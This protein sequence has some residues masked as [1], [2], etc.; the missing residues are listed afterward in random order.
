MELR[1]WKALLLQWVQKCNFLTN[2]ICLEDSEIEEFF[3]QYTQY[4]QVGQSSGRSAS[5]PKSPS[6]FSPGELQ[7]FLKDVYP[8]FKPLLER[9]GRI[10][11]NDYAYVYT[12]LMHYACVQCPSEYFHNI[13]RTLPD[14]TQQYIAAFFTQ[15]MIN[16]DMNRSH[17]RETI[18]GI[19]EIVESADSSPTQP[20]LRGLT[21]LTVGAT[22]DNNGDPKASELDGKDSASIDNDSTVGTNFATPNPVQRE[23]S[24]LLDVSLNYAPSTP[25]TVL[26]EQRTRE[27]LGLR[28]QLETERYEK[29]VLEDQIL[30]NE[31][32]INSLSKENTVK[33]Q[34]L[35]KLE[36]SLEYDS[37]E[38]TYIH[39]IVPDEIENLKRQLLKEINKKEAFL[40]QSRDEVQVLRDNY[41]ILAERHKS[42]EEQLYDCL[43]KVENLELRLAAATQSLTT[44]DAEISILLRDKL[45][46]ERC[47]QE[48]RTEL[49]NGR[50]VLNASSDLLDTSQSTASMNT[51]PETLASSVID[52]QLREK[53]LENDDLRDQLDAIAREKKSILHELLMIVQPYQP[54]ISLSP[55][56]SQIL[57]LVERSFEDMAD[58]YKREQKLVKE[59]QAEI[60]E[61]RSQNKL[62]EEG[63]ANKVEE[64]LKPS[65]FAPPV[66]VVQCDIA[67]QTIKEESRLTPSGEVAQCDI[68]VQTIKEESQLTPPV[69]VEQCDIAVQTIPEPSKEQLHI[70]D[71]KITKIGSEL[72]KICGINR[73]LLQNR[74]ITEN[75]DPSV[76]TQELQDLEMRILSKAEIIADQ[77]K[78]IFINQKHINDYQQQLNETNGQL[79]AA[80]L[81]LKGIQQQL[82]EYQ[83][84]LKDTKEALNHVQEEK[85]AAEQKVGQK[86][87]GHASDY[88]QQIDSYQQQLIEYQQKLNE[89]QKQLNNSQ[90]ELKETEKQLNGSKEQL[91]ATNQQL[92][93]T[94]KQLSSYQHQLTDYQKRLAG[95]Q[96]LLDDHESIQHPIDSEQVVN[97]AQ[98][99]LS[100][101]QKQL[102]SFIQTICARFNL[103]A[104]SENGLEE[105][106]KTLIDWVEQMENQLK[107]KESE[108]LQQSEDLADVSTLTDCILDSMNPYLRPAIEDVNTE[109]LPLK[110]KF[111]HNQLKQLV[112]NYERANEKC[113]ALER[114]V[115]QSVEVRRQEQ[116]TMERQHN[117]VILRLTGKL[118]QLEMQCDKVS[119]E[120][121]LKKL[122]CENI[123]EELRIQKDLNLAHRND[124]SKT[125]GD[126][127]DSVEHKFQIDRNIN[128][129]T[130]EATVQNGN[131]I[132]TESV[133]LAAIKEG[134]TAA[135]QMQVKLE[136]ELR[137]KTSII[138]MGESTIQRLQKEI[139]AKTKQF[140]EQKDELERK[141]AEQTKLFQTSESTI[142]TLQKELMEKSQQFE[143][144]K[145]ELEQELREKT[146]LIEMGES[147]IEALQKEIMVKSQQFEKSR[148]ELELELAEKSK[149]VQMGESTIETLQKEI[150]KKSQQFEKSRNE[151]DLE[152][153][154]KS[155]IVQIG[156][157]TIETLQK[158]IKEKTELFEKSRSELERVLAEKT[159]VL[160]LNEST[161]QALQKE[162]VAKSE[163]LEKINSELQRELAEKTRLLHMGEATIKTLQKEIMAKSVQLE[164]T[165]G[166][167]EESEQKLKSAQQ[168]L[169]LA[170]QK[171][172]EKDLVATEVH[173]LEDLLKSEQHKNLSL[174]QEKIQQIEQKRIIEKQLA[175]VQC[176]ICKR[177]DELEKTK[178][179][180]EA[181]TKRL[182][183]ISI[184][185]GEQQAILSKTQREMAQS[186]ARQTEQAEL[187]I[188]LQNE[189]ESLQMELRKT[190]E[191]AS[192]SEEK[193]ATLEQL[194]IEAESE[195]DAHRDQLLR[196]ERESKKAHCIIRDLEHQAKATEN[197]KVKLVHEIG[198][199]N[200][201]IV[202]QKKQLSELKDQLQQ[203]KDAMRDLII[204]NENNAAASAEQLDQDRSSL[205][206]LK[207]ELSTARQE[208]EA[209]KQQH[210]SLTSELKDKLTELEAERSKSKECELIFKR[211][212]S[213]LS[214]ELEKCNAELAETR[215][216]HDELIKATEMQTMERFN[217]LQETQLQLKQQRDTLIQRDLDCQIL[218]AKYRET[219]EEMSRCEQRLKDHRLEMEGKLEKM[220]S[221]MRTLYTA[222]VSRIKE[223]QERE[224]ANHKAEL[225]KLNAQVAKYEEHTRKLSDQIMRLNEKLLEEQKK[226]AIVSTQLRH[227]QEAEQPA[228]SSLPAVEDWQPFKRPSAPSANLGSNLAMEDEEGE[229]FNNTYLTDLKLG[230]VPNMTAEE[231]QY[232]NS[233]QPPHLKSAYA[234]QYDLG[235][236]EDDIKDGPH[237]LDDSMSALLSTTDG[238]GVGM[239]K[240]SMGTHYKRPGP[241]TPS[242]NGGRLSFG[243]SEPPREI[244]RET[245][246]NNGT[247]K[248]PARFKIFASRF[249]IGNGGGGGGGQCLPRDE[250]RR[251]RK[252][253][254]LKG[255]M[256][257]R[258]LQTAF[259]TSTPRSSRS[260]YDQRQQLIVHGDG[261]PDGQQPLK[262]EQEVTP[263]LNDALPLASSNDQ[264]GRPSICRRR[265]ITT[266][267]SSSLTSATQS[268]SSGRR[269]KSI[270]R[271][272]IHLYGNRGRSRARLSSTAQMSHK[273][274]QQ[275]SKIK[276]QR[277]GCFDRGRQLLDTDDDPTAEPEEV[278]DEEE[279][280]KE[281]LKLANGTY[282]LPKPN[283]NNNYCVLNRNNGPLMAMG[284]T[285]LLDKKS[286]NCLDIKAESELEHSSDSEAATFSVDRAAVNNSHSHWDDEE[287]PALLKALVAKYECDRDSNLAALQQFEEDHVCAWLSDGA[288]TSIAAVNNLSYDI[289]FEELCRQTASTAPFE[290]Q[291]LQY[292]YELVETVPQRQAHSAS[293]ATENTSN[294]S[295]N[296]NC[297][298]LQSWT[299]YSLSHIR[300]HRLPHINVTT[301]NRLSESRH[302]PHRRRGNILLNLWQRRRHRIGLIKS[303]SL[304]IVLFLFLMPFCSYLTATAAV[305]LMLLLL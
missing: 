211:K 209:V 135:N 285:V 147:T 21:F 10:M 302:L 140:G 77:E 31:Q 246:D 88:Q 238:N 168:K 96:K 106:E 284:A 101:K 261:P 34:Q 278:E 128:I 89:T 254:L 20:Q 213:V 253:S 296:T 268:V 56:Y 120:L 293:N 220:K 6:P 98:Q 301:M 289:H 197:E 192:R 48:A 150:M 44:K 74:F 90:Q 57:G 4:V 198:G 219:K 122:E 104:A 252:E 126:S 270:S 82:D 225:E 47:L 32:L 2:V 229:V 199:L 279:D 157:A 69:D 272:S 233:L 227:L 288:S 40:A 107:Q 86:L 221:K 75:Q 24:S 230:T 175:D 214:K 207:S 67:V 256:H 201:E 145:S 146:K 99:E 283:E 159:E 188:A 235:A 33:K 216:A 23:L 25:K 9:N 231:L 237:S 304:G 102:Q 156:E 267:S 121:T 85:I 30:E 11:T 15:A 87:V 19:T 163:N 228:M 208:L 42:C 60:N 177:E 35:A 137:E 97:E 26:L 52:K 202:Q 257:R 5:S 72:I 63:T 271:K 12:L 124:V 117:D 114:K 65:Q 166:E 299:T 149:I 148:N 174:E 194:R 3:K 7:T 290:L 273:R 164:K 84:K 79:Q 195:R 200:S 132:E 41:N 181:S 276:D 62:D 263:H 190:K 300:T 64:A 154:E 206:Q 100:N 240:K 262:Q 51:T 109:A 116:Q 142:E 222:E 277:I 243:G 212:Q 280:S 161:I 50:E 91:Q 255:I 66:D 37:E 158:E 179:Q 118:G 105:V 151:L 178:T 182:E 95:T 274:M 160:Q 291:P 94:L 239:R 218:Q 295:C 165:K 248:T 259:C 281:S 76:R 108:I 251:H 205:Q 236:Q 232:R 73:M 172:L 39:N 242:K 294:A 191:R 119:K 143:K 68:A 16:P 153:A 210:E 123:G 13:C 46:V 43:D 141:L 17:L 38:R 93:G 110:L 78:Q 49:H 241:P 8:H 244:L 169:E 170:L 305:G 27:V 133:E 139:M 162:L 28:A 249:S 59:L 167:L 303:L 113:K 184:K 152:L 129:K 71:A 226:H 258:T 144:S 193:Q 266:S 265:L 80:D 134:L 298:S 204:A 45:E 81:K 36:A 260:F 215:S 55:D 130:E 83:Q 127:K 54:E 245:C 61:S 286:W 176:L 180:L 171:V 29:T 155:K 186:K 1:M 282:A 70:K 189:K 136:Q 53:E 287:Q 125:N 22:F 103:E 115:E 223:K 18:A 185:L 111:L 187:I 297:S 234:A 269:R 250:R 138:Q 292:S 183:K 264:N 275:R 203:S 131:H 196:F 217:E 247:A 224:A 14:L 92:N 173:D 58:R 112:M